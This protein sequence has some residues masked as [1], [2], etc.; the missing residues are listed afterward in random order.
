M[1]E[2]RPAITRMYQRGTAKREIARLLEIGE[3]IVRKAIQRHEETGTNKDRPGRGRKK[4]AR[5]QR[6]IKRVQGMIQRNPKEIHLESWLRKLEF[7]QNRYIEFFA[8][9]SNL[10]PFKF[11]KRQKLTEPTKQ[12]RRNRAPALMRRLSDAHVVFD[13]PC[14]YAVV[15]MCV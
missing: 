7:L 15:V 14:I 10:S 1:K 8:K 9:I 3:S 4:T 6:N 2:L 5:N 11:K 12:K 13:T